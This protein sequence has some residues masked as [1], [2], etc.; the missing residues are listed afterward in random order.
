M[1]FILFCLLLDVCGIKTPQK[2]H[3]TPVSKGWQLV[4]KCWYW[5]SS[6]HSTSNFI[7]TTHTGTPTLAPPP[8][9]P[10]LPLDFCLDVPYVSHHGVGTSLQAPGGQGQLDAELLHV[11]GLGDGCQSVWT[12]AQQE[13][14]EGGL[15]GGH[16]RREEGVLNLG[17]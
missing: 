12:P 13:V 7:S 17:R 11:G 8:P 2:S 16:V 15:N 3:Y 10:P 5:S 1:Y 4:L 6:L 14:T 9:R